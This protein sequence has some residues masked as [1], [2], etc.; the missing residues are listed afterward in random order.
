MPKTQPIGNASGMIDILLLALRTLRAACRER[1][2]LVLENLRLG[3][4]LAV[5]TRPRQRRPMRLSS[6]G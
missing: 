3:Q 6:V 2:Y 4:Q 5:L 1:G